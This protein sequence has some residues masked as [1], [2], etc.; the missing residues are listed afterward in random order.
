ME[1]KNNNWSRTTQF[2]HLGLAVTVTLQLLL[3]LIMEVPKP[4][5]PANSLPFEFFEAHEIV[6]LTALA[7]VLMHWIWLFFAHDISFSKLFPYNGKGVGQVFSDVKS[8]MHKQFPAGGPHSGGLV[9]LV[10]GLGFLAVS[11]M[12]IT[13]GTIFYLISTDQINT[14]MAHAVVEAHEFIAGFVWIYWIGHV[15]MAVAHHLAGENTLRA[16]FNFKT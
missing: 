10:H 8:I 12:V 2:L 9:G 1:S 4:G 7:F 14:N 13:G 3:S 16:M 6:G 15:L 5:E 11:G